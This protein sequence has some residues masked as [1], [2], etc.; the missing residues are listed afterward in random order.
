MRIHGLNAAVREVQDR[1]VTEHLGHLVLGE[2][3][4]LGLLRRRR[5]HAA[6]YLDPKSA[7]SGTNRCV[8]LQN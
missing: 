2:L 7:I 3:L 5:A 8:G 4:D 1:L 6:A